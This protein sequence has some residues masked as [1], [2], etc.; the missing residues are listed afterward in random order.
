M[1]ISSE[2]KCSYVALLPLAGRDAQPFLAA[3]VGCGLGLQWSFH[4]E[5]GTLGEEGTRP[6]CARRAGAGSLTCW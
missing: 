4:T 5:L 6:G 2:M 1:N 3:C